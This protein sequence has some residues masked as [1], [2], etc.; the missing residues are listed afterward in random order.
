MGGLAVYPKP[1][2]PITFLKAPEI[3]TLHLC[4]ICLHY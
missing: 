3:K 2:G 4:V 1:Q